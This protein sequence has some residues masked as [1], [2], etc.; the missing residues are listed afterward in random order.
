MLSESEIEKYLACVR[1]I[2]KSHPIIDVHVHPF[3]VV[4]GGMRYFPNPIQPGVYSAGGLSYAPPVRGQWNPPK[5]QNNSPNCDCS[6]QK[7]VIALF[8]RKL[9]LHTGPKC[10]GDLM[11][12]AGISKAI[13]L[14]VFHTSEEN[15]YQMCLLN[16]I[17]G[18]DNRFAIGYCVPNFVPTERICSFIKEALEIYGVKILKIHPNI[19]KIDPKSVPGRER[20]E[21][22]LMASCKH[23]LKVII[24]GGISPLLECPERNYGTIHNLKEIDFGITDQPVILSHACTFGYTTGE[25]KEF[26]PHLE[27]LLS[28]YANL[29]VDISATEFETLCLILKNIDNERIVFGSDALYELQWKTVVRLLHGIK[30]THKKYKEKFIQIASTNPLK[31]FQKEF[32]YG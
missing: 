15:E 10:L 17:F 32:G 2:A 21:A 5:M 4:Y 11:E 13:L 20:F 16:E 7:R 19:S 3:E 22:I 18:G 1:E 6:I 8:L 30:L 25:V 24:H 23:C 28:R 26:L 12:L 29:M 14:P 31:L 27:K 9:Y